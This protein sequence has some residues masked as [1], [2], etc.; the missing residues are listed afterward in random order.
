MLE[1]E[2]RGLAALAEVPSVTVP[3]MCG[4]VTDEGTTV[5]VLEFLPRGGMTTG[6]AISQSSGCGRCCE[7]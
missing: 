6:A 5:L 1:S 4:V 3:A 2:C 7:M